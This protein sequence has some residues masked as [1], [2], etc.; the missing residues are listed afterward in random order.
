MSIKRKQIK[1]VQPRKQ[2]APDGKEFLELGRQVESFSKD[3]VSKQILDGALIEGVTLT[4]GRVNWLVHG[5]GRAWKGCD[6]V[7]SDAPL[8]IYMDS[9]NDRNSTKEIPLVCSTTCTANLWVF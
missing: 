9:T 1:A 7:S 8:I 6:V 5:L 3:V 4:S 2:E